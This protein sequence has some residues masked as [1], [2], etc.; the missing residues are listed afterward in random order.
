MVIG[1]ATHYGPWVVA[2]EGQ[3]A[4]LPFPIRHRSCTQPGE[5]NRRWPVQQ[6]RGNSL[7][8]LLARLT[9]CDS[10]EGVLCQRRDIVRDDDA[11]LVGG[12]FQN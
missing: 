12:P 5:S 8:R 7:R 6:G 1:A 3:E 2:L 10:F 11:P 4:H 9:C